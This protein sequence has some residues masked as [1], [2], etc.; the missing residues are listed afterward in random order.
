MID[1]LDAHAALAV[2]VAAAGAAVAMMDRFLSMPAGYS[3]HEGD[4]V[5]RDEA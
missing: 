4:T 3:S 5:A 1:V 2:G